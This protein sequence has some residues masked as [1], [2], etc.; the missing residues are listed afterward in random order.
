MMLSRLARKK[1]RLGG[2]SYRPAPQQPNGYSRQQRLKRLAVVLAFL[3]LVLALARRTTPAYDTIDYDF[4]T[5][6]IAR[7]DIKAE[8]GFK[9]EDRAETARVREEVAVKVPDVYRVDQSVVEEQLALFDQRLKAV[10]SVHPTV[11]KAVREALSASNS[12]QEAQQVAWQAVLTYAESVAGKAPFEFITDPALLATWLM[13]NPASL[14]KRKFKADGAAEA[15]ASTAQPVEAL[16]GNDT[17]TLEFAYGSLLARAARQAV[18]YVLSYGILAPDGRVKPQESVEQLQSRRIMILRDRPIEQM[19]SREEVPLIQVPVTGDAGKVL[20]TRIAEYLTA[21]APQTSALIDAERLEQA[22]YSFSHDLLVDTLDL[23]NIAT[24]GAREAARSA[25]K[26]V[27]KD[28]SMFEVI[29]RGGEPWSAQSRSDVRTYLEEKRKRQGSPT[30]V[31]PSTIANALFAGLALACLLR[32][33]K[34]LEFKKRHNDRAFF[35]AALILCGT[36]VLGRIV[37]YFGAFGYIVPVMAG[38]I[39][40]AILTNARIAAVTGLLMA[41]LVSIQYDYDWQLL[42]VSASMAISGAF[43]IFMVRRRSDMAGAA[44]RATGIG[45]LT[46]VAVNLATDNLFAEPALHRLTL[47]ALNG[48]ACLFIVPGLLPPLERLFH[49]T[50]DIQLL[51]YSDLNNEVLSRMAIEVPATFAHSLMLGQLAEAAADAIGA[52]G[53]LARVCAYYHDIG[54]L[55]RPEYFSE[56]QTNGNV[57]DTLS[58][59]LSARAIAAHVIQGAEMAREAHLPKPIVDGILE[60]HG[61]S[62]ISFFYQQA[63][64]QAKHGDVREEDFRYPGPKPQS[65]ETAILMICDAVESGVRSL[66]SPNEERVREFVD[67]IIAARAADR[68]FDESDL[69]LRDLDTIAQVV[70]KRVLTSLHTRIAYPDADSDKDKKVANVVMMSGTKD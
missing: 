33:I 54:K 41:I 9:S 59:R 8:F 63:Q 20:E 22:A 56:N 50:T 4:E 40:L 55:R 67:K 16:E 26:P 29:Q 46:M 19:K 7:E 18:E 27:T 47:I 37:S 6:P 49:I 1:S 12:S 52:N 42:V 28:I 45:I 25:V 44:F 51:E 43:S 64:A 13:P 21:S 66:K 17:G 2:S 57:H 35:A 62:L 30:N 14:P 23:D 39:L 70:S 15:S 38:A 36:V 5:E 48:A 58:P 10:E 32:A 69:T 60:H 31:L 34:L 3:V 68:Q 65:R 11:E 61:T 24:E 53:L